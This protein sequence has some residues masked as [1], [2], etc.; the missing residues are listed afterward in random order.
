MRRARI[1]CALLASIAFLVGCRGSETAAIDARDPQLVGTWLITAIQTSNPD[2][3]PLDCQP[4]GASIDWGSQGSVSCMAND[5]YEFD[6]NGKF[7]ARKGGE[8]ATGTWS[9]SDHIVTVVTDTHDT[10][11]AT[12]T[13]TGSNLSL[14]FSESPEKSL[15]APFAIT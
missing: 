9:T 5:Q 1:S 8:T 14:S 11:A 10:L 3:G 2:A 15:R 7:V 12:Y 13:F 6:P 4:E